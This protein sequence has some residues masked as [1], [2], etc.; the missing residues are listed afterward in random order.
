MGRRTN[1]AL[2]VLLPLAI[3]TGILANGIGRQW[4]LPPATVH[5]AV[6]LAILVLAPWKSLV[7]RRGLRRINRGRRSSLALLGLV[8]LTLATGLIHATGLAD[9]VGPLTLMQVH[10]G[11]GL[12]VLLLAITHYERHPVKPRPTDLSRRTFARTAGLAAVSAAGWLS[13]E[14]IARIAGW[15]GTERRFT[16]SHETGSGR[17]DLLPVTSWLDDR[18]QDIDGP[19]WRLRVGAA[20]LGLAELAALPNESIRAVIDCTGGWYSEQEWTGIRLA[21]VIESGEWPASTRSVEVRSATGYTRRY[22]IGDL[23]R[24]WLVTAAGGEPLGAAHGFPARVVA[25]DRRGFW[26]VKWVVSIQPSTR[27]WWF[28]SPFPL[29]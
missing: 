17:P 16:G 21:R 14:G 11:A 2:A 9:Q 4:S 27:P 12:G 1:L 20:E 28:Q 23:D 3:A 8:L 22:P 7:I 6:A 10:V 24:T 15:P 25:P 19:S 18:V 5:G 26:W 29:T 13:W